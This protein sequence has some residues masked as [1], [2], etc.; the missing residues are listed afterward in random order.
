MLC[1]FTALQMVSFRVFSLGPL[2]LGLNEFHAGSQRLSQRLSQS[3]TPCTLPYTL[4]ESPLETSS[5]NQEWTGL[6]HLC[7]VL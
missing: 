2:L 4:Y 1:P 6:K 3:L 7:K 5:V